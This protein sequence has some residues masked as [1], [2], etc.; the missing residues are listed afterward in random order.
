VL[1]VASDERQARIIFNTARRM[2]QLEPDLEARVQVYADR[3]HEPRTDS[4][5][6]ALPPTQAACGAG[7]RRWPLWM[8]CMWSPTTP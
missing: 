7:I 3:L 6:M 4:T 2:V 1:V 5:F 8:S